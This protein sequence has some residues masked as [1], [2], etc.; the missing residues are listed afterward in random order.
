MVPLRNSAKCLKK[1]SQGALVVKNPPANAG[2]LRDEGLTPL[3]G[4]SHGEGNG[5]PL[6]YSCLENLMDRGAWWEQS[7]KELDMT[8]VPTHTHN[9]FQKLEEICIIKLVFPDTETR[10]RQ[11]DESQ[12]K[13]G[14]GLRS[15]KLETKKVKLQQTTQKYKGSW[16][17]T[18]SS[19][20]PING[21][22]R[23]NVQILIK[24]CSFKTESGRNRK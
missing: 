24:V 17:T 1:N 15:I 10:Q 9:L 22:P 21:Q 2:D 4:R 11:W 8:E 12:K 3:P 16:E 6:H 18:T 7:H 23:R 14:T 19:H 20:M 5:N 13:N